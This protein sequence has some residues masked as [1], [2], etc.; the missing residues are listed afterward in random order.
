M[1]NL[2]ELIANWEKILFLDYEDKEK[3]ELQSDMLAAMKRVSMLSGNPSDV[4]ELVK[5]TAI[6]NICKKQIEKYNQEIKM[7]AELDSDYKSELEGRRC[8]AVLNLSA[9][10][11]LK[12]Q[13]VVAILED[14]E[15]LTMDMIKNWGDDFS[16]MTDEE[17]SQ[18]L[19]DLCKDGLIEKEGENYSLICSCDGSLFPHYSPKVLEHKFKLSST[20]HKESV[21]LIWNLF[22]DY[23]W[24]YIGT[25]FV[26]NTLKSELSLIKR[27]YPKYEDAYEELCK[28]EYRLDDIL[29]GMKKSGLLAY[30][31]MRRMY[32]VPLVGEK[33]SEVN[34]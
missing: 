13:L 7:I 9:A 12:G 5:N 29:L 18:L 4:S 26:K 1:A 24:G 2:Q 23:G 31:R 10:L 33:D 27:F 21:R 17:F 6:V 16:D 20:F 14:Q 32:Y 11:T 8:A 34:R 22:A 25:Y 30:D 3:D 15:D 19:S 28:K